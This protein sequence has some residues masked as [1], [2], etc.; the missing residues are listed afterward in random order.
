MTL[1]KL[2]S[3][4]H[5][6]K[7]EA[8]QTLS[9][10][11]NQQSTDYEESIEIKW[12][13]KIF[14]KNELNYY[15]QKENCE[16]EL[17][18]R[19]HQMIRNAAEIN[20]NQIIF[21]Y[22]E[23]D[24]FR[25]NDNFSLRE[26]KLTKL[27]KNAE[28][29]NSEKVE[30][31]GL[32]NDPKQQFIPSRYSNGNDFIKMYIMADLEPTTLLFTIQ[33]RK[34][35]G[36]FFIYP[37]FN[38]E[39]NSYYL[40]IDQNSK[41]MYTYRM[42]NLSATNNEMIKKTKQRQKLNELQD[43]TCELLKKLH[44]SAKDHNFIYPK[45]C[46]MVFILDIISGKYFEFDNIHVQ[47]KIRLPKFMKLVDGV[48]VG[49]TH[50]SFKNENHYWNFGTCHYLLIDIDDEFLMSKNELD[51]IIINFDIISIDPF[52]QR[53]NRE[54]IASIKIPI[55]SSKSIQE[56]RLQCF[57]DMQGGNWITDFLE[58]FF[59]GG[60]RNIKYHDDNNQNDVQNFYGNSTVT[61]GILKIK[62][63]QIRQIRH[64]YRQNMKMQSIDEIINCYH[65]A[66][67]KLEI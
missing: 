42:E 41:Q 16:S 38:D 28:E 58:R 22:T 3:I 55:E 27:R 15:R 35:D 21:T 29:K 17:E 10:S 66:K 24:N 31:A 63:Q 44:F 52:W 62:I 36:L 5:I 47:F 6:P 61:T 60:I 37:D 2:Y 13:E 8:I 11:D 34:K 25:P 40:E 26:L 54:G 9:S 1:K 56:V 20:E 67:A 59:L 19:Y 46:R 50:S 39:E 51:K 18:K 48:L 53:E 32:F 33:Y 12:H 64:S 57:R 65:K 7:F 49:A 30:N 45:F 4:I 43:E 14:S 23:D